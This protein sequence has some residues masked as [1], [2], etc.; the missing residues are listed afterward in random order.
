M[1]KTLSLTDRFALKIKENKNYLVPL[2]IYT[3]L[4]LFF[5]SKMSPLYPINEW[6][7]INVYFN[8]GKG[9]F[10]GMTLYSE[11]FDHKGP[12]IFF[13]YGF[14]S[15]IS[16][17]SFIGVFVMQFLLW[18][19]AIVAIFFTAKL[20]LNDLYS[21]LIAILSPLAILCYT[22]NGGSAEEF[23]MLF[24]I[25]SLY[26]FISYF[27]KGESKHPASYMFVHGVLTAMTF[28]IKLN[29]MLFW[30]FPLLAIFIG[31]LL[32][33]EFK[34]FFENCLT[35]ILGFAIVS[36]PVLVYFIC[37]GALGEAYHVYIELNKMY[38]STDDYMY[39]ITNGFNKV[40]KTYRVELFWFVIITIGIF[41]FPIKY[42]RDKTYRISLIL[43]SI[44]LILIIFFPLTF[45]F[46]YPLP[47]FIFVS[48]GLI[49]IFKWVEQYLTIKSA[50]KIGLLLTVAVLLLCI[51]KMNF[52]GLGT[53]TLL[54]QRYP[55]GP[56]FV[57]KDR[58]KE[59]KDATL[60]SLAFGENVALFTT[61][62]TT[63]NLKYF[64]CPNIYYDMFPDIRDSHAK[65]I[66][67][68]DAMYIIDCNTGFNYD[69]FQT[70]EPL[71]E[72]YTMIDSTTLDYGLKKFYL[73]KRND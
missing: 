64:F 45:H 51:N 50:R 41:Y 14:G 57:F 9:V 54:R 33:K 16:G 25:I 36:V 28:L 1:G 23:I 21:Y 66:E 49:V 4:F 12:M 73:Y 46:Y 44:S 30:F 8:V 42:I 13:I 24:S 32:K 55:D 72:N 70:F 40:Y 52:F 67:N 5:C 61:T 35:Y 22:E 3:F 17:D 60:L 18:L 48:L 71:K 20:F 29:L 27:V 56:Q 63:P 58:I 6:S 65:Y 31:L 62:N 53:E 26:F 37:N 38:S 69:F 39:L 47:I 19:A 11:V 7:D 2:C 10:N 34:N 68:K 59:T 15:L 43:S